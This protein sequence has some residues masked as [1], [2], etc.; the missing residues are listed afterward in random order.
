[1]KLGVLL[2]GSE[3]AKLFLARSITVSSARLSLSFPPQV[4]AYIFVAVNIL[5]AQADHPLHEVNTVVCESVMPFCANHTETFLNF[6][7]TCHSKAGCQTALRSTGQYGCKYV[8]HYDEG[9]VAPYELRGFRTDG[10]LT[11][12]TR[13]FRVLTS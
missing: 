5:R 12:S 8:V 3:E 6:A 11:S 4:L 13:Q 2:R 1:M 10:S 9:L 7:A